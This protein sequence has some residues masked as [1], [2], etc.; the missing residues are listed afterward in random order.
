MILEPARA[1]LIDADDRIR[2]ISPADGHEFG[3]D[4]VRKLVGGYIEVVYLDDSRIMVVNEEGKFS[5]RYNML[6]TGIA[7]LHRALGPGDYICGDAV[8]C[9]SSMLP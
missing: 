8:V 7:E 9:P 2:E 1:Y 5:K 6:A 3:L 4:E